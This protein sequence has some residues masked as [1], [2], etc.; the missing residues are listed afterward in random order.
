[1]KTSPTMQ[2]LYALAQ[3]PEGVTTADA[4]RLFGI[5]GGLIGNRL[6]NMADTG[7]IRREAL[8]QD[9]RHLWRFVADPAVSWSKADTIARKRIAAK[10]AESKARVAHAMNHGTGGIIASPTRT[11]TR[12]I[13]GR[14][15]PVTIGPCSPDMRFHVERP[16]RT[17]SALALGSYLPTESAI[18]RAYG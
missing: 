17:F 18:S 1:M 12:T 10:I 8:G 2:A 14:K 7:R 13:D 16:A 11:T 4:S 5:S 9:R 3:R 15:V 6:A